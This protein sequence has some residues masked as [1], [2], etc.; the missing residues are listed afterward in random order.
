[1]GSRAAARPWATRQ[2]PHDQWG[3]GTRIP[4]L[5]IAPRL[6]GSFVVD[7]TE[8]DTTSI[9][10]TLEHRYGLAPLGSRDA[11]VNDLASVFAA[12]RPGRDRTSAVDHLTVRRPLLARPPLC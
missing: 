10:S 4:A 5:V 11:A 8:H 3:P 2:G 9:L 7:S 12:G 6:K 1:M